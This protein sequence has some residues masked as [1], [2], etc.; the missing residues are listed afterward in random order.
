MIVDTMILCQSTKGRWSPCGHKVKIFKLHKLWISSWNCYLLLRLLCY[1]ETYK[2]NFQDGDAYDVTNSM[3]P[4]PVIKTANKIIFQLFIC[5]M[6]PSYNRTNTVFYYLQTGGLRIVHGEVLVSTQVSLNLH[7]RFVLKKCKSR[8]ACF[9]RSQPIRI[10]T[11]FRTARDC[12]VINVHATELL[13]KQQWTG[14]INSAESARQ[15][16]Q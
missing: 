3:F 14:A 2:E 1:R 11:V 8:S 15:G 9:P 5:N 4:N 16:L 12:I 6:P 7:I 13:E 10:H